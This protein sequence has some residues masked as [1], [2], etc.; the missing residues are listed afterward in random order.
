LRE[1]IETR[2]DDVNRH[3]SGSMD[4]IDNHNIYH[5]GGQ[6]S[7][8]SS[9]PAPPNP[10][11]DDK[12]AAFDA[13]FEHL[14]DETISLDDASWD[15]TAL[16]ALGTLRTLQLALDA[17]AEISTDMPSTPPTSRPATPT[18]DKSASDNKTAAST[19]ITA[20]VNTRPTLE[21]MA[22]TR[23]F[24]SKRPPPFSISSYGTRHHMWCPHSP[25]VY[26]TAAYYIYRLCVVEKVLPLTNRTVHR[27]FLASTRIAAKVL[28]DKLWSQSRVAQVG[29]VSPTQ[30]LNLEITL[31]CLLDFELGVDAEKLAKG[32]FGLQLAGRLE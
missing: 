21:R 27:L 18:L 5:E 14:S 2:E 15:I 10:N 25:G 13:R 16:S 1:D 28:E 26:L 6:G 22:L 30:L 17:L 4:D 31:C 23:R 9:P 20:D 3:D 32:M 12:A 24:F 19:H 11:A 8:T 29:G 7:L